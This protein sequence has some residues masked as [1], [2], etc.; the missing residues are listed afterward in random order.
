MDDRKLET[1]LAT[2]RT[3]SFSKAARE[4]NCTQSAVTQMMNSMENE[5]G[6]QILERNHNGVK[7]TDT[8]ENLLPFIIEA[9]AGLSR[10]MKY[11]KRLSEGKTIPIRIGSFSSISNTWLPEIMQLYQQKYPDISFDIRIGSNLL[12]EWLLNGEI[13]LALG[14][15]DRC[16]AFRWY[17]LTDDPYYAVLPE[18]LLTD[19]RDT[20]S[21]EE[22]AKLPLI[23]A[24]LNV[25]DKHLEVLV[26][27]KIDVTCDD[28]S[29]LL[30][31]VSQGFGVTAMPR[32]SLWNVPD[33]VR[34]LNL[35]SVPKRVIG[36]ALPNSPRKA[37]RDFTTFLRKY[38]S[39]AD[40]QIHNLSEH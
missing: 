11:A 16:R 28:D 31:M 27:R 7:L 14:D 3:G 20:I 39:E 23:M 38:F 5:L 19:D 21:Q 1:L 17:P 26:N 2:I 6:C 24:P 12:T 22:F 40:P 10:L 33:N 29:T 32:L 25:L 35:T 34:I 18:N 9:D 15:E 36:V 37:A 4:L 8:G 13:D 30:N